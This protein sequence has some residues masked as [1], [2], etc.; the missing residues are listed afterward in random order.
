M[1]EIGE[2]GCGKGIHLTLAL[3]LNLNVVYKAVDMQTF[4]SYNVIKILNEPSESDMER[5]KDQ[6]TREAKALKKLGSTHPTKHP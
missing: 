4:N 3:I 6:F 5:H 1:E 2:G